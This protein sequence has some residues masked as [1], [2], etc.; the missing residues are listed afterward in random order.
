MIYIGGN[1]VFFRK[2]YRYRPRGCW[3]DRMATNQAVARSNRAR[4]AIQLIVL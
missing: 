2:K 1:W 3:I 4:R